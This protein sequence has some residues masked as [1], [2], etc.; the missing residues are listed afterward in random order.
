[1]SEKT[2]RSDVAPSLMIGMSFLILN[3]AQMRYLNAGAGD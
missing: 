1:M 2:L 3:H